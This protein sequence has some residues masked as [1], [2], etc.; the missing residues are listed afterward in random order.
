LK[1]PLFGDYIEAHK[2]VSSTSSVEGK[3]DMPRNNTN[4]VEGNWEQAV[5]TA[6]RDPAFPDFPTLPGVMAPQISKL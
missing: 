1:Q 6:T 3:N 5:G 4:D 2:I